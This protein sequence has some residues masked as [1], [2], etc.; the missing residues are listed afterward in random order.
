MIATPTKR[1]KGLLLAFIPDVS[2][3]PQVLVTESSSEEED[4]DLRIPT[5]PC[6][7]T[8]KAM[9][10]DRA[11]KMLASMHLK[12]S[13]EVK[14]VEEVNLKNSL[15]HFL[16]TLLLLVSQGPRGEVMLF[17]CDGSA[18]MECVRSKRHQEKKGV[19]ALGCCFQT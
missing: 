14:I 6:K 17:D 5:G 9:A 19:D 8:K 10:R 12:L 4:L 15:Q 1:S 13:R 16:S 11:G 18:L 7:S 3:I 2:Q